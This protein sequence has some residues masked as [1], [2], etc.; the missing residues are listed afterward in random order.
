MDFHLGGDGG[1]VRFVSMSFR[2]T[3]SFIILLGPSKLPAR[4]QSSQRGRTRVCLGLWPLVRGSGL[5]DSSRESG[6]SVVQPLMDQTEG[7]LFRMAIYSSRTESKTLLG[8]GR[9]P[10]IPVGNPLSGTKQGVLLNVSIRYKEA[11]SQS[12]PLTELNLSND[13]ETCLVS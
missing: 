6:S 12:P 13:I 9:S 10:A 11:A 7:V 2:W 8:E 1:L 5:C 4:W 3:F